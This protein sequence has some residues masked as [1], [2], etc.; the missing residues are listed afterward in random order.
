[1]RRQREGTMVDDAKLHQFMGQMLSD[2]GGA[3]SIALVRIGDALG[4]YKALHV[5]GP[6]TV[7]ELAAEAG[8]HQRYL[9]EWLSHQAASNYLSYDPSTQKFALPEEQAMVFAIEDSPVYMPGAFD[10]MAALLD[11]QPKVAAAF[12]TGG[13]V[14]WG[15]HGACLF[16]AVA[17]FFRPGYHNNLLSAWLPALDGVVDKLNRGA[18]VADVGCGHGWS[19]VTMAK[20]FPNSQFI[21]YDFHPGSIDAARVHAQSHGVAKNT[22]FEV[23]TAKDY[24]EADLDLVTFFDC[25]HDMGDPAGAAAH[26]RGSLRPDGAWMVVEPIAGDSLEQNLNPIGRIYYAGSTMVCVA[27]SLSQ[28]VGAALGA[29]AGE[30]KLREVITAGG[31]RQVRRATETPFNMILEARP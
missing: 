3:A 26:V 2:L 10:L 6:M 17:R 29:Q 11:S 1:M 18:R 31:F 24:G 27:T 5:K 20:A 16:C 8:V 21:G 25:L 23:G 15:D 19:T 14:A 30:A 4:L 9:R 12:R 28:E 13:G 7:A 22:R